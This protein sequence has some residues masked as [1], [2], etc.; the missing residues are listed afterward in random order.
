MNLKPLLLLFSLT[1]RKGSSEI[2]A[3]I[4]V[5]AVTLTVSSISI[6]FL[7]QRASLASN[8][9]HQES[10]KA[11]LECLAAVKIVGLKR[12]NNETFLVLYNPS[13]VVIRPVALILGEVA[14]KVDIILEPMSIVEV[15]IGSFEGLSLDRIRL[16]TVE[17]VLIDVEP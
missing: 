4:I 10:K 5:F 9:A 7:S 14:Q 8:I 2:I 12:S 17:G 3:A 1:K 11:V 16:L 6:A 15:P 13:D